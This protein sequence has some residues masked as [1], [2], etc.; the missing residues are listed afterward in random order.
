VIGHDALGVYFQSFF[1]LAILQACYYYIFVHAP[2]KNINPRDNGKRN[3][4][5]SLLVPDFVFFTHDLVETQ[6]I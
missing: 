4:V 6:L 5:N 2:G 3:N 1:P